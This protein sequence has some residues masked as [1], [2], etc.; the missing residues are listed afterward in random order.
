MKGDIL[1]GTCWQIQSNPLSM[2]W[3]AFEL[4]H[5]QVSSGHGIII[6]SWTRHHL[7]NTSF[8]TCLSLNKL[9]RPPKS[10]PSPPQILPK[11]KHFVFNGPTPDGV[12]TSLLAVPW[13]IG[14][15]GLARNP[16]FPEN[17]PEIFSLH[18]PSFL[19]SPYPRL[20]QTHPPPPS[21]YTCST[22]SQCQN[23]L[24]SSPIPPIL[25]GFS[26]PLWS[27]QT[28]V[29]CGLLGVERNLLFTLSWHLVWFIYI[30]GNIHEC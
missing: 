17:L 18:Y 1:K 10:H 11:L 30:V 12:P 13:P 20:S 9:P 2:F 15:L 22:P 5:V 6:Y 16:Y 29:A 7:T 23:I 19:P 24:P 21:L 3:A 4:G 14:L 25:P 28:Q 26:S 27:H 8:L